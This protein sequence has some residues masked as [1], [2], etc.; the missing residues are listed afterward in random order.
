MHVYVQ[1]HSPDNGSRMTTM[2]DKPRICVIA[3]AIAL[4]A[5]APAAA[6][7][8]A[9]PGGAQNYANNPNTTT[10][11]TPQPEGGWE[12]LAKLLESAK[13]STS[14]ALPPTAPQ[15]TDHFERM[16]NAN[17]NEQALAEIEQRLAATK[18]KNKLN[19]V[20]VQLQF[21][22]AR[23]LAANGRNKE[24]EAIY[25]EMTTLY[26]ELPEPWNN[27]AVLQAARGDYERASFSLQQALR[28]NPKFTAARA[29][30]GDVQLKM[31]QQSYKEA[32]KTFPADGATPSK[33]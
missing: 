23:A 28:A 31:A 1:G 22:H 29:N 3:L 5:A 16:L 10:L 13:P 32:G 15:W 30:L 26:P 21:Q 4:S 18:N 25:G 33:D 27:L 14:T 24:A 8:Q 11:D 2:I 9:V 6:W 20:D 17:R 19:G 12:A 7:A